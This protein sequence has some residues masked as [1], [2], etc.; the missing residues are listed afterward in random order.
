MAN[1]RTRVTDIIGGIKQRLGE[2]EYR[3][4]ETIL[5][6]LVQNADD[7]R[8]T[9]LAF[10]LLDEG[11]RD[12]ANTLLH[13]PALVAINDGAFEP[14]HLDALSSQSASSKAEDDAAIGR[15]GIGQKSVFHL[16]EAFCFLGSS[17]LGEVIGDVLDPWFDDAKGDQERPDWGTFGPADRDRLRAAVGPLLPSGD[18]WFVLWIPLRL[19]SHCRAQ[20]LALASQRC[21]GLRDDLRAALQSEELAL[22]RPQLKHLRRITA[23]TVASGTPPAVLGEIRADEELRL[24][25]REQADRHAIKTTMTG[26]GREYLVV[27]HQQSAAD[28]ALISLR[29]REGWPQAVYH[30]DQFNRRSRP[31]KAMAHG[32]ISVV[33]RRAAHGEATAVQARWAVFL[34]VLDGGARA[35]LS[36]GSWQWWITFH[37][38]WFLDHGRRRIPWVAPPTELEARSGGE[39]LRREWNVGIRDRV[40]LPLLLPAIADAVNE[41][42]AADATPFINAIPALLRDQP[43]RSWADGKMLVLRA[44]EERWLLLD[45]SPA[46]RVLSIPRPSRGVAPY[47]S[48]AFRA[49]SAEVVV[50]LDDAPPLR[51]E[52]VSSWREEDV[53][54]VLAALAGAALDRDVV[55][56]IADWLR[57]CGPSVA[58]AVNRFLWRAAAA[59]I[60]PGDR[61]SDLRA[62]QE[63][64]GLAD[65]SRVVSVEL[66][67]RRLADV[68]R[69]VPGSQGQLLPRHLVARPMPTRETGA[70]VEL[71]R[72]LVTQDD[73]DEVLRQLAVGLGVSALLESPDLGD[74]PIL[75]LRRA[76]DWTHVRLSPLDVRALAAQGCLLLPRGGPRIESAV[77]QF[78][79]AI[80]EP[81]FPMHM[82]PSSKE[83]ADIDRWAEALPDAREPRPEYLADLLVT[84]RL[85][86]CGPEERLPLFESLGRPSEGIRRALRYLLHGESSH[87]DSELSLW[88]PSAFLDNATTRRLLHA[89]G[90]G[91]RVVP[92]VFAH[93]LSPGERDGLGVR[94]LTDDRLADLVDDVDDAVLRTVF[95]DAPADDRRRVLRAVA[96]SREL[97]RRL[98]VHE[99]LAGGELV[100]AK[101]HTVFWVGSFP[102]HASLAASMTLVRLDDDATVARIQRELLQEW[103]PDVQRDAAL[104]SAKNGRSEIAHAI[105]AALAAGAEVEPVLDVPWLALESGS[106]VAPTQIALDSAALRDALASIRDTGLHLE[107]A[108]AATVR[109]D[110]GWERLRSHL[111]REPARPLGRVCERLLG[112]GCPQGWALAGDPGRV[113]RLLAAG[114]TA[115]A[116]LDARPE[117]RFALTAAAQIGTETV[118]HAMCGP[119]ESSNWVSRLELLATDATWRAFVTFIEVAA[120]EV[121]FVHA[122]LPKLTLRNA[123][124]QW[125]PAPMIARQGGDL[126]A[127]FRLHDDIEHLEA[128][129]DAAGEPDAAPREANESRGDLDA[130]RTFLQ[131]GIDRGLSPQHAAALL[132]IFSPAGDVWDELL[133]KWKPPGST[134]EELRK[135]V[136]ATSHPD[137]SRKGKLGER[138]PWELFETTTTTVLFVEPGSHQR[139]VSLAGT[140]L[141]VRTRGTGQGSLVVGGNASAIRGGPR[142]VKLL[143]IAPVGVV[144]FASA[145][146]DGVRTILEDQ[147]HR[148]VRSG[149]LETL[150]SALGGDAARIQL[151]TATRMVERDLPVTLRQLGVPHIPDLADRL[152]RLREI[153]MRVSRLKE[154]ETSSPGEVAALEAEAETCRQALVSLV[155]GSHGSA[156]V[157]RVRAKLAQFQYAPRQVLWELLQN[158]DDAVVQLHGPLEPAVA[159]DADDARLVDVVVS[160][161]SDSTTL[162]LRHRGRAINA[163]RPGAEKASD[164]ADL[165]NMLVLNISE[166]EAEQGVTGKFGLGFKSVHLLTSRPMVT[167]GSLR[168]AIH[169]GVLPTALDAAAADGASSRETTFTLPLHALSDERV[170]EDA[171]KLMPWFLLF[172]AGIRSVKVRREASLRYLWRATGHS[173][174]GD[175]TARVMAPQEGAEVIVLEQTRDARRHVVVLTSVLAPAPSP[176]PPSVWVTAPVL[177]ET[178]GLPYLL[179]GPLELDVGRTQ[180]AAASETNAATFRVLGGMLRDL[181]AGE[182]EGA[183]LGSQAWGTSRAARLDRLWRVFLSDEVVEKIRAGGFRAELVRALHTQGRGASFLARH[184]LPTRLPAPWAD[185][186]TANHVRWYV[187]ADGQ[188]AAISLLDVMRQHAPML[189]LPDVGEVVAETVHERLTLLDEGVGRQRLG[190]RELLRLSA[191]VLEQIDAQRATIVRFVA[192]LDLVRTD[193]VSERQT[194]LRGR[195]F[196]SR[197]GDWR[198]ADHLLVS[199]LPAELPRGARR[200][201]LE[202]EPRRAPFAPADHI[203]HENLCGGAELEAFLA[204]R[205]RLAVGTARE[206]ADWARRLDTGDRERCRGVLRYLLDGTLRA[207]LAEELRKDRPAWVPTKWDLLRTPAHWLVEGLTE[208]AT[209]AVVN[210][211]YPPTHQELVGFALPML[212]QGPVCNPEEELPRALRAW[213]RNRDWILSRHDENTFGRDLRLSFTDPDAESWLALF[214]RASLYRIGRVTTHQNFGFM[215]LCWDRGWFALFAGPSRDTAF[216]RVISELQRPSVDDVPYL[217]WLMALV[218]TYWF[219]AHLDGYLGLLEKLDHEDGD[220]SALR[221]SLDTRSSAAHSGGG[222]DLPPMTVLRWGLPF[223][224]RE[225]RRRSVLHSQSWDPLCFAT[226]GALRRAVENVGLSSAGFEDSHHALASSGSLHDLLKEYLPEDAT[227]EGGFDLAL[228]HYEPTTGNARAVIDEGVIDDDL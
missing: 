106:V 208:S 198:S 170:V 30:D 17:P 186:T 40:A 27:S 209:A 137:Q 114:R 25:P 80:A 218:F 11:I 33:R 97:A 141:D 28:D 225:L 224:L 7:A 143:R 78:V 127:E 212:V 101:D 85:R 98:P 197:G 71:I 166:K 184:A 117:W 57:M 66:T 178:W 210:A 204:C 211:L 73:V 74:A 134:T 60:L 59:G 135:K 116:R 111:E 82:V 50:V 61:S 180:L 216:S 10:L 162:S 16:C 100:A 173:I 176:A 138:K 192:S 20:G 3:G 36:G 217:N 120:D 199:A 190:V 195:R 193:D 23:Y 215:K 110:A 13:G 109:E 202:D 219:A 175:T 75:V 226:N 56:Y 42:N 123:N 38:Y 121:G 24:S 118:A 44:F 227:F 22:L 77:K 160:H 122:I 213:Q 108:I 146:L 132:S 52:P 214:T 9:S 152:R 149:A 39:A 8:A 142:T 228:L 189:D 45:D 145:L 165:Y 103:T 169:G 34:P 128:L 156:V 222:H 65:L 177:T 133:E 91:W 163:R 151:A 187:P 63:L 55:Q 124:G 104:R 35:V 67:L 5:R 58:P 76:R 70:F 183:G 194:W 88:T 26:A 221:A 167:S 64:A 1:Y 115:R 119:V 220:A 4:G 99:P 125:R 140:P 14:T 18:S 79:Q 31:E 83:P 81:E 174:L 131:A 6:E 200:D 136:L 68:A 107:T 157:E 205:F 207:E 150:W 144:E 159:A 69:D 168:F 164:E 32:G 48:N 126:D 72:W 94:D 185:V 154:E 113:E 46:W 105:L 19:D 49:I 93:R 53:D 161:E 172:A 84:S 95:R 158:A 43:T 147:L 47:V 130:V 12:A 54:V 139:R 153:D 206:L 182:A 29:E 129:F 223:V 171:Q 37:G 201:D 41:L 15:F 148:T 96:G 21:P 191:G 87:I 181:A 203:L 188:P 179:G 2:Y 112:S 155:R 90:Q 51:S 62:W 196:R 86:L 92:A 89:A 102:V